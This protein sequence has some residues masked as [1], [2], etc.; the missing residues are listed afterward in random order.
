MR[1][2]GAE[3]SRGR[4]RRASSN[5]PR[6]VFLWYGLWVAANIG[7]TALGIGD[8]GVSSHLSLL[9]TG[10]PLSLVSLALP[11]ASLGGVLVA[12]LLGLLQ[13]CVV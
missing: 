2:S 11:S 9:L 8:G 4:P 1:E 10:F 13:W 3:S 12:G 5:V 6:R 7:V